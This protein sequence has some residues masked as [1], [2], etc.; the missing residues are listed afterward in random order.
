MCECRFIVDT[1]GTWAEPVGPTETHQGMQTFKPCDLY[2]APHPHIHHDKN[3]KKKTS[4][5]K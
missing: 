2:V 1:P 5:E 3:Y 4:F